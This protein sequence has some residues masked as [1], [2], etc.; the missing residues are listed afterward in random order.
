MSTALTSLNLPTDNNSH[1]DGRRISSLASQMLADIESLAPEIVA[2]AAEFENARRIPF[3][4]I[5]ELK[6]IGVF[7]MLVP[8]SHGGLEFDL[9]TAMDIVRALARIDGSVG[10]TVMIGSGGAIFAPTL[11]RETFEQ[12]YQ[13]GPNAIIA[14]SL[15]PAGTAEEVPSGWRVRGRWPFASGCLHADWMLGL[16]VV[17]RDGNPLS[18]KNGAPLTR[19]FLMPAREWQIEDTW[20]V[21]GLKGTGSHHITFRDA[22][23]PK[24][25]FFDLDNGVPFLPGPLYQ[26]VL[27]TLPVLH[28]AFAVGM[29]EG[30]LDEIIEMANGGRVQ[31]RTSFA[32]RDSETFQGEL[33]RVGAKVRA[34][35]AFFQV[36]AANHWRDALTGTLRDQAHFTHAT[37]AAIWLANTAVEIAG[38]CFALGGGSALYETSPL[39]RRLRDM[40]AAAQHAAVQERHYV[41]AG[42]LMLHRCGGLMPHRVARDTRH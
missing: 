4:V 27:Q 21:A 18:G 1:S 33:G 26:A 37:Q 38:K 12:V 14:G 6:S 40:Q 32:M 24:A 20:K 13:H 42:Q 10:W 23:V 25:N 17:T 11:Q 7:R 31:Q 39:Q 36:Q 35:R 9:P 22:V 28:G 5:D 41:N 2:R 16:C 30:A 8:R 15:Q 3:D 19:S 34:A 29:G